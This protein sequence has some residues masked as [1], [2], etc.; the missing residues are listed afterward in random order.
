MEES[1]HL[2]ETA[3]AGGSRSSR[4]A[5]PFPKAFADNLDLLW[6]PGCNGDLAVAGSALKCIGCGH[7]FELDGRIPQLFWPNEGRPDGD[8]T[9][10]VKSFYEEN[11]FP[12]YDGHDSAET[13]REKARKG[14]YAKLLDDQIPPY[15]RVLEVGCGTGQL[16]NFLACCST[17]TMFGADMCLN[18]LRLG[19][20]FR[21]A[22]DL[23][24]LGFCQMNLFKPVF[25]TGVFDV[26]ISNGVL[27]HT[28][29]PFGGFKSISRLV[30]PGGVIMIGLYNKYGRLLTDVR[31]FLFNTFGEGLTIFDSRLRDKNLDETRRRTWF[32][33]QY[34]HPHESKHT[35]GEVLEWFDTTGF[36]FLDSVPKS[37]GGQLT[38]KENLF[39][40]HS[41]GSRFDH[42]MVQSGM[43]IRGAR[44]GGLFIMIGRQQANSGSQREGVG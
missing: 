35:Y 40:P 4:Q 43:I 17:R 28:S 36:R 8:V 2:A 39:E 37:R 16:T 20:N 32:M 21:H 14:I 41:R 9:E 11:P 22:N 7:Q 3:I 13:L 44:E 5:A 29:D 19:D 34:K 1:K 33:D 18:S 23:N 12:N 26:V 10:I 27:H 6:C 25:R 42:F 24:N 30:K 31:R 38:M 15:A